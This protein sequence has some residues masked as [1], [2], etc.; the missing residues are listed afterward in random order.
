M[1]SSIKAVRLESNLCSGIFR[2]RSGGH[3]ASGF[4]GG[5]APPETPDF[6]RWFLT[7]NHCKGSERSL[8]RE[9]MTYFL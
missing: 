2:P 6:L 1:P 7:C 5:V 4:D 9:D 3:F 8:A